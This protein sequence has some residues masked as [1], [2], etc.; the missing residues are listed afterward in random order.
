M[1]LTGTNVPITQLTSVSALR[2]LRNLLTLPALAFVPIHPESLTIRR[3]SEVSTQ[4][5]ISQKVGGK[6]FVTDNIAPGPR[7]WSLKGYVT[8]I[9]FVE[10]SNWFMPSLQLQKLVIESAHTSRKP[11]IF[12]T[13]DGEI[14]QVLIKECSFI[15]EPENMN[16]LKLECTLQELNFLT[17]ATSAEVSGTEKGLTASLPK[18]GTWLGPAFAAGG[19]IVAAIFNRADGAMTKAV[20]AGL[21]NTLTPAQTDN[22]QRVEDVSIPLVTPGLENFQFS[23]ILRIG[24]LTVN[25]YWIEGK[26]KITTWLD[27]PLFVKTYTLYPNMVLNPL[28]SD[29]SLL[30]LSDKDE[31][32][33]YDL[34]NISMKVL[35]W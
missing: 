28:D 34:D 16:T 35:E 7:I 14:V 32:G 3:T 6:E 2:L 10:L 5:V 18:V 27:N 15:E 13:T 24:V 25:F 31:I 30:F 19:A 4:L 9:P 8:G 33:L 17:V 12:R 26:W 20:E 23:A 1:I 29:Y 21:G 22:V 11:V